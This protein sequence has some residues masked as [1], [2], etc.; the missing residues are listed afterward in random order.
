MGTNVKFK[1]IYE[2]KIQI[3]RLKKKKNMG[4]TLKASQTEFSST[5]IVMYYLLRSVILK[6]NLKI[7]S[8]C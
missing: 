2:T 1:T 5:V 8:K 7:K 3:I 4:K 6:K